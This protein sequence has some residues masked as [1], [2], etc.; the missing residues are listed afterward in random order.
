MIEKIN[1]RVVWVDILKFIGIL[2]VMISHLESDTALLRIFYNPII[3]TSFFFASGY[4]YKRNYDFKHFMYKKV[5]QLLIPWL[6]FSTFNIVL[7]SIFS[8]NEHKSLWIELGWN[9]LQVRKSTNSIWFLPALFIAFIPFYFFVIW[10]ENRQNSNKKNNVIVIVSFV[11]MFLSYLYKHNVD[12]IIFPWDKN[13]LPWHIDSMF[14]FVFYMILGFLFR[15]KYEEFFDKYNNKKNRI[16]CLLLY[17]LL[18]ICFDLFSSNLPIIISILFQNLNSLVGIIIIISFSKVIKTNKYLS[19]V[20]QHTL[21]YFAFHGKLYSV[22]QNLL[23]I[24]FGEYYCFI[25]KNVIFSSVFAIIFSLF[26]SV[27]LIIPSYII[28]KFFPFVIGKKFNK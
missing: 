4:V 10:I 1:S 23:R 24:F 14:I 19:Y 12:S 28:D 15:T 8:F 11:L 26:L 5:R 9:F 7:A 22:I 16:Y 13:S 3:I 2:F 18:I 27:L 17:L 25:L 20:G 6:V 21:V